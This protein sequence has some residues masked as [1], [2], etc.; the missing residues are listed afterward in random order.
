MVEFEA[1]GTVPAA[2]GTGAGPAWLVPRLS[3]LCSGRS[4]QPSGI[5]TPGGKSA[6]PAGMADVPERALCLCI[7][8]KVD[9]DN[10]GKGINGLFSSGAIC[11]I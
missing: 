5:V 8:G 3:N 4:D 10:A 7:C 9:V 2:L 11:G 6:L 1:V